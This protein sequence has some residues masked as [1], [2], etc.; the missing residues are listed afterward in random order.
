V[1]ST[2]G[3]LINDLNLRDNLVFGMVYEEPSADNDFTMTAYT[4]PGTSVIWDLLLSDT[5]IKNEGDM[6][7]GVPFAFVS[8]MGV[9]I[10]VNVIGYTN[11]SLAVDA[12]GF[13]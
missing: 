12:D 10:D 9:S 2:L 5:S 6:H 3:D 8:V 4:L 1:P 7:D 11:I 13:L